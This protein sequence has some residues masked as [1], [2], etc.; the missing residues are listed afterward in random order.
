MAFKHEVVLK[1]VSFADETSQLEY[2]FAAMA[3][4]GATGSL[5]STKQYENN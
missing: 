1:D 4:L 3:R 5:Y 2:T